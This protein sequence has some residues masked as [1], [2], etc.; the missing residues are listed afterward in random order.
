[1]LIR[2][3]IRDIVKN[4]VQ[5]LAI[6]LMMFLG[7]FLFSGI[8]GEWYGMQ[9]HFE[10]FLKEQHMA[11]AW[12]MGNG[13]T[14]EDVEDLLLDED[15]L[16]AQRRAALPVS[17]NEKPDASLV[18]YIT[19]QNEISVP[20]TVEGEAYKEDS[21]GLW[22]DKNFADENR[23]EIGETMTLRY[24]GMEI[25]GDIKGLVYSP[26][27]IYGAQEG[28]MTPDHKKFGFVFAGLDCLRQ[29]TGMWQWNQLLLSTR[30]KADS[31]R[32]QDILK[33][34]ADSRNGD[35]VLVRENHPS[36]SMLTDEITQHKVVG[37]IF[38]AAFLLIAVMIAMTTMH[39][40]LK[41][42]RMQI[43]VM[44][45]LGFGRAKLYVH[46]ASHTGLTCL[47]GAMFGYAAG[48][49][50]LPGVIYRFLEEM[51][52]LPRW[53][54]I[55]PAYYICLPVVCTA[56]CVFVSLL[57]CRR[58]LGI[59]AAK[60]L[61]GEEIYIGKTGGKER[62]MSFVSRWNLRDI[63]RNRLRS[64]MTLCGVLGCTAL[65]F[66]AFGLYDTFTRLTEWTYTKQQ[67]YACRIT[68]L[69]SK[70]EQKEELLHMTDGEYLMENTAVIQYG[71]QE[72]EVSLTVQESTRYLKL[73]EDLNTQGA[74]K[75]GIALSRKTA[76]ALGISE[77][78]EV[79]WKAQGEDTFIRSKVKRI[80]LTPMVQG[81]TILKT[82]YD[83]T[84]QPFVP[85]AVIGKEP[86]QGRGNSGFGA[87]EDTCTILRQRDMI[88]SMDDMMEGMIIM[89]SIL[90]AG[91]VILG[92]VMLYN[93]GV[94]SY[95][96][97]Y[98][99]FATLKVLG[100]YNTRVREIMIQQNVWLTAIGAL[101][102]LPAGYVLIV[103]ML[104]TVQ[105]SLDVPV[106]IRGFSWVWTVAG[107]LVLSGVISF[108]VSLKIHRIDM[109]EALKAKE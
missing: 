29:Y 9:Q 91:A 7:C 41:N 11:D 77:G 71:S 101:L 85:T 1:M 5:F 68:N 13:Y 96:E 15:I 80:I 78:D 65:L 64:F 44:K 30:G 98:R 8:T 100:F 39:R 83:K 25:T 27:Y 103:Y 70:E 37:R 46:Y 55:L 45:A 76:E 53:K 54:G 19:D 40:M 75:D 74:V 18:C 52:V 61:F 49:G 109:A 35:T 21:S 108:L 79:R 60:C 50:V 72:K 92:S 106:Y 82:D 33:Q 24:E 73:Y 95:M 105:E 34:A 16:N 59:T 47:A 67:A 2:K 12:V 38:S 31:S 22:L 42:Q 48:V 6:F 32:I 89:I 97:R 62:G 104:S 94:L 63:S 17:V 58:Y 57:I 86:E 43:G 102:G 51:Y 26:E 90:V 99:E 87:F 20:Y 66:G 28:Q 14:E 56:A 93:L 36:V 107:T 88:H 4:K 23:L 84:G 81:I 69:P 10:S 3:T